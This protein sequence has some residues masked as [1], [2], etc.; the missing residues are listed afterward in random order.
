M[1]TRSNPFYRYQNPALGQGFSGL[2][3][4][5][6]P[7]PDKTQSEIQA[8]EAQ[9]AANMALAA[10]RDQNTRGKTIRNDRYDAM[11]TELAQLFMSGGQFQDEAL[12][13]NPLYQPPAPI[14]WNNTNLLL[15]GLPQQDTQ[16][17]M[18]GGRTAADQMAAAL[19]QMEAYGFRPDQIMDAIGRMEYLN[20]AG[21]DDPQSALAFAPFAG[22][23]SPNANTA[24]TPEAQNQI[25]ARNAEES[26]SQ[27]LAVQRLQNE[28]RLNVET[29]K[30]DWQDARG[31]SGG[32]TPTIPFVPPRLTADMR[33]N[34]DKRVKDMGYANVEPAAIDELTRFATQLYQ[35]PNNEDTFKNSAESVFATLDMLE[36]GQLASVSETLRKN[37]FG[38][39]RID[40][41]RVPPGERPAQN[42]SP[43]I[44]DARAA[45]AR[46]A[47]RDAVIQRL[48]DNGITPP[49][50]L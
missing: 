4:A 33:A 15:D 11:P 41:N 35:D 27:A 14:D 17:M 40:L 49:E 9:A 24:L 36:A 7:Q 43:I 16:P 13:S 22:V 12:T 30:Q 8:R 1:G 39:K 38:R 34:I 23:T 42:E 31:P 50:D 3:A 26:L 46:G 18:L 2:A 25:S 10:E 48:K 37:F 32:R 20:R 44:T 47:P 29:L 19:Q 6:F 21:G 28:G 45:I 5:M